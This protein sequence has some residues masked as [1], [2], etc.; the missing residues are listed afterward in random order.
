MNLV[1]DASMKLIKRS[2]KE[3]NTKI[4]TYKPYSSFGKDRIII[5]DDKSKIEADTNLL[6]RTVTAI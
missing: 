1:M 4:N 6:L 2:K 3:K 5:M